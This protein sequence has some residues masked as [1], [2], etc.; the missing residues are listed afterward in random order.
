MTTPNSS[1]HEIKILLAQ[2]KLSKSR[3]ALS[4]NFPIFR[5]MY[6]LHYHKV[7]DGQ[8]QTEFSNML[9]E[10]TY[11][12]GSKNAVASPREIAKTTILQE[13]IIYTICHKLE[14]F[15]MII[16][17]TSDQAVGLVRDIKY[18]LETNE[19]LIR[20]FPEV[21]GIGTKP[22]PARWTQKELITK[23]GIK[24][25]GLGTEQQVRGRRNREFRPSLIV[26]DD[27][28]PAE[29]IQNPDS[30]YKLQ[31]LLT[32]G[33]LKSGSS[34]TNVIYVGTIHTYNSLLAQLISPDAFPGWNKKTYR[35]II[36]W[37]E[38]PK[39]WEDWVKIFHYQ[40]AYNGEEGPVAAH[41]FF[42]ANQVAMLKGTSVLWPA[43]KNYYD[44]MV[45]REREGYISFDSE[46]QNDPINPRDC[47]FNLQDVHYWDDRFGSGEELLA[48]L[49]GHV[50]IVGACDP[51]M[52]RQNKRSDYSAIITIAKDTNT[53]IM[54]VLD[55]DA[56]RRSPDK[57]INDILSHHKRRNYSKFGFESVQAQ[58]FM[59]TTLR[60]RARAMGLYLNVIEIKPTTDKRARI[61]ALQPMIKDGTIQFSKRLYL[62]LEQMKYFP[63]GHDDILDGLE[64]SCKVARS[65]NVMFWVAGGPSYP[66]DP[67]ELGPYGFRGWPRR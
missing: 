44:L 60:D 23:N 13:Y 21:C 56:E 50:E 10:M 20:D 25:I 40:E 55:A 66:S 30:Y 36:S 19:L 63:R 29:S 39:L 11:K 2:T 58:E 32:K 6:F 22:E 61:E 59:A 1:E 8:F 35:S 3:R 41:K 14:D 45:I 37:S 9:S 65:N 38:E 53:G 49:A 62:L 33:I 26:L 28:E 52:G 51:S 12:R 17:N 54:Y 27:Y 42:G 43:S 34:R 7:P 15:I 57:L 16:S 31:D 64:M 4:R 18:E 47:H 5:Q 48:F 67:D 46:M 24:I